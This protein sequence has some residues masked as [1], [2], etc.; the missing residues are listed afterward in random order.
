MRGATTCLCLV[1]ALAGAGLAPTAQAQSGRA[2]RVELDA[3]RRESLSQTVPV[4]GRLV[5]LRQGEVAA[6]VA[7][8]VASLP[9]EVGDRVTQGQPLALLDQ[10]QLS[11]ARGLAAAEKAE[12]DAMEDT[13]RARLTL[14]DQ[15]L[16]RADSLKGSTAFSG[17]RREDL[18]AE[19]ARAR[20]ELREAAAQRQRRQALLDMA[21]LA[22]SRA[23]VTA[24]YDGVVSR[25]LVNPGQW[26]AAGD[27]V[28]ALIDD[29]GLEIEAEAPASLAAGLAPGRAVA[30]RLDDGT[31]FTASIR[32]LVPDENPMTRTR[33]L[34]LTAQLPGGGLAVGQGVTL[35][36]PA[37][38][39]REALTMHKD[40]LVAGSGRPLVFVA[41]EGKAE[42]REVELGQALGNRFE[43]LSGLGEGEEV[44]IRGNERLQDGQ[45]V[46]WEPLAP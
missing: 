26:V 2:A 35:E 12:A 1:L 44:I 10:E 46:E 15:A 18:A 21:E 22:L 24:P 39:A 14:A 45:A 7:G 36:L 42:E 33:T 34:R 41:A 11:L 43:V 31:G 8:P 27:A 40:A 25:R 29:T 16:A 37:G 38:G 32:A 17:A 4:L 28:V 19:Q 23:T 5:A 13:A 3:V 30:A 6:R 20:A 9:V